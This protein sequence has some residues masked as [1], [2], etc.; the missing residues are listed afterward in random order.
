MPPSMATSV[1]VDDYCDSCG[2]K[3]KL[4]VRIGFGRDSVRTKGTVLCFEC[5]EAAMG[6]VSTRRAMFGMLPPEPASV[7]RE[8]T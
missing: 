5:V 2:E 7:A 1:W 4:G 8:R 3:G 6:V